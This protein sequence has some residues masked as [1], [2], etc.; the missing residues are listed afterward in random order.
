L[1]DLGLASSRERA[2]ALILAG[3]VYRGDRPIEKAGES[4]PCDAELRVRGG[5]HPYV[6]RGGLKLQGALEAFRLDPDGMAVV[7]I[8]ASTG[9]FTDC[10]LQ[11]GAR[12]V[13][14][15]DVGYGQLHEKIRRDARVT[16]MDR[17]NARHLE[18]DAVG[19][20]VDLV[21]I[22]A[23]FISLTKLLP[24]A[25]AL[26]GDAGQILALVKPQFEAD[27]AAV[28]KK[29]VVRDPEARRRAIQKIEAFAVEIGLRVRGGADAAIRGPQGNLEHFLWL[30]K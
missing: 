30:E 5:D 1:V 25:A 3:K 9:G 14:A 20:P 7:D 17:T 8:G 15:V 10:L 28:G 23:S 16:V 4:V 21:V 12:H 29:G 6:S 11:A 13:T 18:T 27:R 22:D 19:G 26:L 2:R 24:P